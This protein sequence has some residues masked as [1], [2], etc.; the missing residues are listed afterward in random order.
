MSFFVFIKNPGGPWRPLQ[1]CP[2]EITGSQ[3]LSVG[4]GFT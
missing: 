4:N 1:A 2:S 3:V